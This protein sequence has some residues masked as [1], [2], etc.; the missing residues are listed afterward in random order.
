[1]NDDGGACSFCAR[2]A[3]LLFNLGA[4]VGAPTDATEMVSLRLCP[5]TPSN[6]LRAESAV[7]GLLTTAGGGC[8]PSLNAAARVMRGATTGAAVE[9]TAIV[10]D[11]LC[12]GTFANVL[13]SCSFVKGARGADGPLLSTAAPARRAA[14]RVLRG[15]MSGLV[16]VAGSARARNKGLPL[17]ASLLL[18]VEDG[19][20]ALDG[21]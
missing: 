2:K 19:F 7:A 10:S 21:A 20:V 17:R 16:C 6:V 14:A 8:W 5:G 3:A 1:M 9:A 13:A 18:P 11:R 12:P 15:T 4:T